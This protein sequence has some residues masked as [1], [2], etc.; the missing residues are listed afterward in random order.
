MLEIEKTA[1]YGKRWKLIV[2]ATCMSWGSLAYGYIASSIGTTI[3]QPSFLSYMGQDIAQGGLL[4]V[5]V[6]VFYAGGFVGAILAGPLC[7]KYG[8]KWTT[9][10]GSLLTLVINGVLAGSV[11]VNMFIAFR[12]FVDYL[13]NALQLTNSHRS[14]IL[15]T[16]VPVWISEIVPPKGRGMLVD[17][18]PILINLGY[19]LASYVGVG[20]FFVNGN[21]QQWRGP[22]AIGCL[23]CVLSLIS[24]PFLPESPRWLLMQGKTNQAWEI[25]RDLH[26][27]SEVND[28]Q[29]AL[30]EFREMESQ[31]DIDR[32]LAVGYIEMLRRPSYRKR[33]IIG[34]SLIFF[35][36]AS[37]A[38]VIN[39]YGTV[40]YGQLGYNV[41]QRLHLQAGWVA[42]GFVVNL[43]AVL[44]VD[45][46]PRPWLMTIGFLGCLLTLIAEAAIQA[47]FLG[48]ENQA[49]LQAGVAQLYIFV[50][51]YGFFLDGSTFCWK[52]YIPFMVSTAAACIVVPLT[53]PDTRNKPLEEI[54]FLFGEE[55]NISP[56]LATP[57]STKDELS[58]RQGIA[59]EIEEKQE[60]KVVV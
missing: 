33:L 28:E 19:C 49:A 25:V 51:F 24:V 12:F 13:K 16:V 9:F 14:T 55:D 22:I 56:A 52:Y 58:E 44:V 15:F 34:S 50:F 8:R 53:F 27:S 60:R 43:A 42:V 37:G 10:A 21:N 1:H 29:F 11:N 26:T 40:L 47:K 38:L 2:L 46:M 7:D 23:P 39:N 35:L 5:V 4:S 36:E 20:F 54:A 18:H 48:T 59:A 45:I 32:T 6:G 57:R 17:I 31:I 41:E 30:N 3:G